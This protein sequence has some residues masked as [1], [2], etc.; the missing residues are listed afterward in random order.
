MHKGIS[1]W[2]GPYGIRIP[3]DIKFVLA[4]DGLNYMY[5]DGWTTDIYIN[6]WQMDT[7]G[8]QMNEKIYK[9]KYAKYNPSDK[10]WYYQELF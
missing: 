1:F 10:C 2:I 3:I 5:R 4:E 8:R 9:K 7:Y 6:I